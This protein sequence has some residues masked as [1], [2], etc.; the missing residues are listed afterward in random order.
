MMPCSFSSVIGSGLCVFSRYQIVC[1]CFHQFS[2]SGGVFEFY[3]GEVF[4]GKGVGMCRLKI[5]DDC[6]ISVYDLHVSLVQS[7]SFVYSKLSNSFSK[8]KW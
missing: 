4:A 6:Y 7:F 8:F 1:S 5:S 3:D 2:V